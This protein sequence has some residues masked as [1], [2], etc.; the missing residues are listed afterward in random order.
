MNPI[1]LE[2]MLPRKLKTLPASWKGLQVDTGLRLEAP[3]H[4]N[5]WTYPRLTLAA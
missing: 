5:W 4:T 2:M 3:N 1:A